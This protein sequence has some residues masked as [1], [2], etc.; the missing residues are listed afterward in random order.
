VAG[1]QP[2]ARLRAALKSSLDSR[3]PFG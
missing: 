2:G 3:L 1:G